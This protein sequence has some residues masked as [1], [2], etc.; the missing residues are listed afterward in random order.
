MQTETFCLI[1]LG[2]LDEFGRHAAPQFVGTYLGVLQYQGTGSHYRPLV[3][4]LVLP[5]GTFSL[6]LS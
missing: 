6:S 2:V 3:D 4:T 1:L 5:R